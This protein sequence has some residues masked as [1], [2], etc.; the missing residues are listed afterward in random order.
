VKHTKASRGLLTIAAGLILG[1]EAMIGHAQPQG[2][3]YSGPDSGQAD[4]GLTPNGN[5]YTG[6]FD[7]YFGPVSET[8]YYNPLAQTLSTVGSVSASPTSGTF[9]MVQDGQNT[10][11]GSAS[12]SVGNNGT[13]SLNE[14][15]THTSGNTY[16]GNLVI[17]VSGTGTYDGQS[18]SA[19]WDVDLPVAINI[20]SASPTSL[21]FNEGADLFGEPAD[22][23]MTGGQTV[24]PSLGLTDGA[25]IE[26]SIWYQ[27][28]LDPVAAACVPDES[29]SLLLLGLGMGSV[30][31]L[32]RR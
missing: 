20:S 14:T 1:M 29:S 26:N 25:E 4:I 5:N 13:I 28:N 32:R 7:I 27:W 22:Q 16:V 15:Y 3:F 24:I 30:M 10:V 11:V 17:P 31:F 21:T 8:L 18:F 19:N 12:L 2:Y 23:A 9:N 6:Y